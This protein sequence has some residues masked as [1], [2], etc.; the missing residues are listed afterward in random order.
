ML[1]M[2]LTRFSLGDTVIRPESGHYFTV[3]ESD[4]GQSGTVP[5]ST[6][7]GPP[8]TDPFPPPSPAPASFQDGQITWTKSS[9]ACKA[10]CAAWQANHQYAVDPAITA[11]GPGGVASK[12]SNEV[13]INGTTYVMTNSS[14]P[15]GTSALPTAPPAT[16][17]FSKKPPL[18]DNQ[19]EWRNEPSAA[20]TQEWQANTFYSVNLAV[21]DPASFTAPDSCAPGHT[22]VV[23]RVL[24]GTSGPQDPSSQP[25]SNPPITVQDGDLIWAADPAEW[26]VPPNA[27]TWEPLTRFKVHDEVQA[28]NLLYYHV[29]RATAGISGV[30]QSTFPITDFCTVIDPFAPVKDG[31]VTWQDMGT[32]RPRE[33]RGCEE[34]RE[35]FE[36]R[37]RIPDWN[38]VHLSHSPVPSGAVI[39]EP[40][41]EG[42]RYYKAATGGIVGPFTPFVNITPPMLITWQDSGTT[43]PASVASGQPADQVVSL[44][45]LTLPQTHTLARFN[46]SA[47]VELTFTRPPTFG[48][49]VPTASGV[50]LP[51]APTSITST[52]GSTTTTSY[53]YYLPASEVATSQLPQGVPTTV[54]TTGAGSVPV[55]VEPQSQC[56]YGNPVVDTA[57]TAPSPPSGAP[58][59][60]PVYVYPVYEC[61]LKTGRG[62]RPFDAVL[63]LT[64]YLVPVD[65]E[66]PWHFEMH[67]DSNW[68]DWVPGLSLGLSLTNPT[69]NFYVGGS[70]EILVRDLQVFYGASILNLP[71][72]IAAST[73]QA[74][75]GGQGTSPSVATAS[76]FNPHVFVGAT[77]NL[78]NFVSSLFGGGIGAK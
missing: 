78:S 74:V 9:D 59:G 56:S 23:A 12:L 44:I 1:W 57:T 50:N 15:S 30:R 13:S 70:N 22:Y 55:A 28:A 34:Y 43:A 24:V 76:R 53:Y 38:Q 19:I 36:G 21:C 72:R 67:K 66:V 35:D 65:A 37:I 7:G 77:F 52:N 48:W 64:G 33:R 6:G 5:P 11:V 69:S 75:W 16:G 40:G 10:P 26:G 25:V 73:T 58:T 62:A 68:R 49:V 32:I 46:I 17:P 20:S 14:D 54:P 42:G 63:A 27:G 47:G 2:P 71:Y 61:P 31:S 8:R 51:T 60:S 45:N 29:V 39:F 3:V 4:E 18:T 41:E